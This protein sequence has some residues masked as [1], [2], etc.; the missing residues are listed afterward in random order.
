MDIEKLLE[1][2]DKSGKIFKEQ[3]IKK[4]YKSLYI[5]I[6]DFCNINNLDNLSFKEKMY[7]YYHNITN[8]QLCECG[9]PLKMINF[10]KGYS[11]HCSQKC[12]HKD[13]KVIEKT[14]KTL[15]N[16]YGVDNLQKS[17]IIKEKTN[18]TNLIKYGFKRPSQS[19]N[20][21]DKTKKTNFNRLGVYYPAQDINVRNK[22]YKTIIDKNF[23][24]YKNL[25]NLDY[26]NKK[27]TFK[28]DCGKDHNFNISIELFQNRKQAKLSL[29]TICNTKFTSLSENEFLELF[30]DIKYM[31]NDR[32]IIKPLEL[33]VY[34]PELK[35][36]FEFN[37]LYWHNE[38]NKEKNYHLNKTEL[39]EQ[40]GI[41]L[42][43]IYEDDWLYKQNIVKSIIN[44]KLG[45]CERIFA[46][47]CEIKE[48]IDNNLVRLFLEDNHIQGFV[49]SKVKIGLFYN[50]ELISLMTFGNRRIAMGKKSTNEGEYEL[51]R[52]CN[53][54]NI[55]VVGGASKLFKYFIKNYNPTEITTY[56]DRSFS[57][58]KL[59]ETLGFDF[60]EK[61]DPNY[62]YIID[63]IRHHRFNF[64]KDKL[65]KDGFDPNKTEHQ[66]MLDRKL[67]RIFDS[68]NL[69]FVY[70][71]IN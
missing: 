45:K 30:K 12:T 65:I 40:Q 60:I 31:H 20:I 54:L 16:K 15:L 6:L 14:K 47:K 50:N 33:D 49:G 43:H 42:I 11:N 51:L 29:C 22:Y 48:I 18:N 5:K 19:E 10:N 23:L 2:N 69:K 57:Q 61:T 58:G 68:G 36:A 53:K 13:I 70:K 64:R 28:C 17:D 8:I 35:I 39:C 56:A 24:K 55:N 63:G 52:F 46:R 59:Y 66:I 4:Y 7:H 9:N 21:K 62:Y 44:N 3:Y 27:M 67:Y 32:N 1:L 71:K 37:G 41:Q 26:E 25:I 38:L 34:I